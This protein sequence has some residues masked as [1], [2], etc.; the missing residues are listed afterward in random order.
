MLIMI[1][2][3]IVV[4][5]L[6]LDISRGLDQRHYHE[7]SPKA[8]PF[9]QEKWWYTVFS[10]DRFMRKW[11]NYEEVRENASDQYRQR[12][13]GGVKRKGKMNET[14]FFCFEE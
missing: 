10:L 2:F 14:L 11:Y 5:E 7:L 1:T 13:A 12:K 6:A 3:D 9:G 8:P 4:S